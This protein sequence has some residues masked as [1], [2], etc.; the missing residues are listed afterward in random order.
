MIVIVVDI[1]LAGVAVRAT[2]NLKSEFS[3][4]RSLR[5]SNC[6]A[7]TRYESKRES[8]LEGLYKV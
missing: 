1:V 5:E 8:H 2:G 7:C 3:G 6:E 4:A